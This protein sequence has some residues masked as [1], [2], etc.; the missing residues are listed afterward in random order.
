M[1]DTPK[2][3]AVLQVV[4]EAVAGG[5]RK[6]T[7]CDVLGYDIRTI[8]RWEK[9]GRADGRKGSSRHVPN[10]MTS[11]EVQTIIDTVNQPD[12]RGLCPA[13]IVAVLGALYWLREDYFPSA[14]GGR[15]A[16]SQRSGQSQQGET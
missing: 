15:S 5:L 9:D 10:K 13:E 8:Q 2:R 14:Q 6:A 12:Y 16:D 3:K 7:V 11:K 1:T 4:A